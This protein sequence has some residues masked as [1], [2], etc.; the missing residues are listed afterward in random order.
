MKNKILSLL[1]VLMIM[2]V[3]VSSVL[4]VDKTTTLLLE[5]KDA[6]WDVISDGVKATVV[7]N[8]AGPTFDYSLNAQGLQPSTEY[9][10]IYYADY[11]DRMS[12][13][14]GD[15]PGALIGTGSSDENGDLF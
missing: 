5:N 6:N 3:S 11:V 12:E 7:F 4:A 15:N 14:G 8:N 1:V 10:L 13:W 2:V 9:S